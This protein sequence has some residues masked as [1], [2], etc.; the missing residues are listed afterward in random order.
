[1]TNAG[2]GWWTYTFTY[3]NSDV[4]IIFNNGNNGKQTVNIT[5][6][7]SDRC[8][9]LTGTGTNYGVSLATCPSVGPAIGVTP[10]TAAFSTT[11]GGTSASQT[12]AV[13]GTNLTADIVVTAPAYYQVSKDNSHGVQQEVQYLILLQAVV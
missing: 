5:G 12:F 13:T 1:M 2:G 8:Y 11:V 6:V 9:T 10:T 4:T 7:N 3:T